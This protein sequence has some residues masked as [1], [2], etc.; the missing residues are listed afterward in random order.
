MRAWLRQ[1]FAGSDSEVDEMAVLAVLIGL[2]YVA[3]LLSYVAYE[4]YALRALHQAWRPRAFATG[5]ML[6]VGGAGAFLSA[7]ATAMGVKARLGG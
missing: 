6:I 2:A 4:G 7:L 5:A 1:L 3:L